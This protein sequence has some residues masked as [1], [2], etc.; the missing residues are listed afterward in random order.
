MGF[1]LGLTLESLLLGRIEVLKDTMNGI[2]THCQ[3]SKWKWRGVGTNARPEAGGATV[4][5]PTSSVNTVA[6]S[7][8]NI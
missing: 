1:D 8:F 2:A 4:Y 6:I 5:F 3:V 7:S